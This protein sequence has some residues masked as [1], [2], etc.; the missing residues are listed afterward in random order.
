MTFPSQLACQPKIYIN[1]LL[2]I[3]HILWEVFYLGQV[4]SLDGGYIS[5]PALCLMDCPL[6]FLW[7]L[8]PERLDFRRKK[9][10][11]LLLC[12]KSSIEKQGS[13]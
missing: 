11:L 4:G 9:K 10:T 3:Y 12:I 7:E 5:T 6:F 8:S 1:I 2:V 13:L